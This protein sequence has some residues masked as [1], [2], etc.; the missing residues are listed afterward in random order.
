MDMSRLYENK[1]L[2][3][4]DENNDHSWKKTVEVFKK[5]HDR[6]IWRTKKETGQKKYESVAGLRERNPDC[7]RIRNL[8]AMQE[9]LGEASTAVMDYIA[10]LEERSEIQD[11]KIVEL[12]NHGRT[13]SIPP[14]NTLAASTLSGR[15]IRSSSSMVN[16][17]LAKIKSA[18]QKNG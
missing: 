4:Y 1:F 2:E 17:H 9:A 12:E 5:Y 18:M 7:K 8:G 11:R 16:I 6:E 13:V 14:I 15:N 3:E 10:A